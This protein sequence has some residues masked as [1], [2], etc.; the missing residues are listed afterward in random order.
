[1]RQ[2]PELL[3]G[4]EHFLRLL[5][6]LKFALFAIEFLLQIGDALFLF[7]DLVED[8]ID[9]LPFNPRLSLRCCS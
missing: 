4:R 1:M 3:L 7:V 6:F 5:Q 2:T 9:R 8:D